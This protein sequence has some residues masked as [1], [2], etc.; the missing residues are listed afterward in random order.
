MTNFFDLHD[1]LKA[2]VGDKPFIAV[3]TK[4]DKS[5]R[6]MKCVLTDDLTELVN[7]LIHVIEG[8]D[9]HRFV[10]INTVECIIYKDEIYRIHGSKWVS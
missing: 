9:N 5:I 3:F 10:N 6:I 8:K 1:E 4:K 2:M 7:G